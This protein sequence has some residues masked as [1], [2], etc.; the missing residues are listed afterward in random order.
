MGSIYNGS[1]WYDVISS[2]HRNGANDGKN[3]GTL[4][5]NN[6]T[7]DSSL[8]YRQQFS[9]SWRDARELLD[10]KNYTNYTLNKDTIANSIAGGHARIAN[11]LNGGEQSY[12]NFRYTEKFAHTPA[13]VATINHNYTDI[14]KVSVYNCSTTGC[15]VQVKNVGSVG[16]D[17]IY[18]DWIAFDYLAY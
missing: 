16:A 9:G 10:S 1:A 8:Y 12:L 3:Y 2:R 13:V 5:Y 18:V 17:N 15:T 11:H 7:S 4:L 14:L 6:L